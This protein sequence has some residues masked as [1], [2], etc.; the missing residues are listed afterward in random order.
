MIGSIDGILIPIKGMSN[1]EEHIQ[2]SRKN[3]HD[4]NIQG[5]GGL[6][7]E[8]CPDIVCEIVQCGPFTNIIHFKIENIVVSLLA[9]IFFP[10]KRCN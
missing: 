2:V 5:V 9:Y 10:I 3:F 8:V 4:L 1:D 7:D 6:R